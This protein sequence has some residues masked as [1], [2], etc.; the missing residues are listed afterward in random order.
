MSKTFTGSE[1]S[2]SF[3]EDGFLTFSDALVT[4]IN[5]QISDS[6]SCVLLIS[7]DFT[8]EI[9]DDSYPVSS[10]RYEVTGGF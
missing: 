4:S 8:S 3:S 10:F 6:S 5:E 1:S 9:F 7:S 2:V